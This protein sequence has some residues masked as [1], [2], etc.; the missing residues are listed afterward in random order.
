[1]NVTALSDNVLDKRPDG[2]AT[3]RCTLI[4]LAVCHRDPWGQPASTVM[5]AM[6]CSG[7][8]RRSIW[9]DA[10]VPICQY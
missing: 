8:Y 10:P 2:P 6:T 1:V 9:A 3:M 4:S 7:R 5:T